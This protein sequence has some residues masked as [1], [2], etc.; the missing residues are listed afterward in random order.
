M[1]ASSCRFIANRCFASSSKNAGSLF[2]KSVT[3]RLMASLSSPRLIGCG[4]MD[5]VMPCADTLMATCPATGAGGCSGSGFA[6]F[7]SII[8][9]SLLVSRVP[10]PDT[11]GTSSYLETPYSGTGASRLL[12]P[13]GLTHGTGTSTYHRRSPPL[14]GRCTR[15]GHHSGTSCFCGSWLLPSSWWHCWLLWWLRSEEH[16]S[17][18]QSPDHLVC[19]LLLEKQNLR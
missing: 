17:E 7:S 5:M 19:R 9:L 2:R 16:T 14:A 1:I 18:L 11:R 8:L 10:S 4:M 13:R 15:Y 3:M 12:W 6:P